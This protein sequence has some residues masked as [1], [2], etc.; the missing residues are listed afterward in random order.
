LN[1]YQ[2]TNHF[3]GSTVLGR[4]DFLW[5]NINRLRT[6][7]PKDFQISPLSFVLPDDQNELQVDRTLPENKDQLYIIKPVAASCG[8]GIK[9]VDNK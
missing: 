4:K 5:Q 9:I 3:P 6:R 2:K 8:R 7:F 1:Q